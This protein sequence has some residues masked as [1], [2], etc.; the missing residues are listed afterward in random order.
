MALEKRLINIEKEKKKRPLTH[1]IGDILFF[2]L[3]LVIMLDPTNTILHK[4]DIF[5]VIT[6]GFCMCTIKPDWS[7]LPIILSLFCS[8][9][10]PWIF[11]VISNK[12][13]EL[14]TIVALYKSISPIVLLLWIREFDLVRIAR[15]PVIICCLIMDALFTIISI[16]PETESF[17]FLWSE[18]KDYPIMMARR[19]F[20][21]IEVFCMY[22]KSCISFVFVAIFYIYS[23]FNKSNRRSK[24]I[25]YLAIILFAFSFSGTR[26]T[27][28]LP[29][30]LIG[31]TA[32]YQYKDKKHAKYFMY[33]IITIIGI[34]FTTLLI[35]LMTD[36]NEASNVVKYGHI[37]SYLSLFGEHP[38]YILFGQGPGTYFY[39]E[40][41]NKIVNITEWSYIEL[42]RNFG[43]FALV[44][45][46]I[47]FKPLAVM[48]ENKQDKLISCTFWAYL[49]YLLIAGT[50]PLLLSS[51][52]MITLLMAYSYTEMLKKKLNDEF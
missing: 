35:A 14:D 46:C 39:S 41:F 17:I 40:G 11:S 25:L 21:G 31:I 44:I 2:F 28:L 7:K 52:G 24:R 6:V 18:S 12:E 38:E 23:F 26:S 50:N 29:V 22:L 20:L 13:A 4:K 33:P 43:I 45:I 49:A 37:P 27:M 47:F 36:T 51:T 3:I 32:Y 8:I 34:G 1:I 42:F 9:S 15:G 10:I 16:F 30:F 48:W 19:W 5:F